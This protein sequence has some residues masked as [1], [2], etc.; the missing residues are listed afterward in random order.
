[1]GA[2]TSFK[3]SPTLGVPMARKQK[4]G[5]RKNENKNISQAWTTGNICFT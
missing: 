2:T 1:M 3:S 4:E 5:M